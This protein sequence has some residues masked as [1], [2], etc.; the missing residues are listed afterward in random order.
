LLVWI[1]GR[2][3]SA[4]GLAAVFSGIVLWSSLLAPLLLD[5]DWILVLVCVSVL[6]TLIGQDIAY[7]YRK[8]VPLFLVRRDRAWMGWLSACNVA[9]LAVYWLVKA[10]L[11]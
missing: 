11:A 9:V 3:T 8:R 5:I 1:S 2:G 10:N 4:A 7:A 6:A